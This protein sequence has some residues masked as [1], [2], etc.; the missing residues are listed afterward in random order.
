MGT[1]HERKIRMYIV[2][3]DTLTFSSVLTCRKESKLI[4]KGE[5]GKN[6]KGT[7][8][9]KKIIAPFTILFGGSFQRIPISSI[10]LL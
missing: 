2:Q 7:A 9:F 1:E 10:L 5:E 3:L 6:Q 8:F 4:R